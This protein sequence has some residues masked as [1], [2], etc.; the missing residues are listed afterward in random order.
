MNLAWILRSLKIGFC[1]QRCSE[2]IQ[3]KPSASLCLCARTSWNRDASTTDCPDITELSLLGDRVW[4][5]GLGSRRHGPLACKHSGTCLAWSRRACHGLPRHVGAATCVQPVWLRHH[6]A[7]FVEAPWHGIGVR[8]GA[9]AVVEPGVEGVWC[10]AG[11]DHVA[12]PDVPVGEV[13]GIHHAVAA[14]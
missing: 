6:D 3:E 4:L 12:R 10:L 8:G 13:V 1:A 9:G 2:E 5:D 7:E 14:V 11:G